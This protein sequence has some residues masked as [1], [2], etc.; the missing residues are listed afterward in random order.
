M[1]TTLTQLLAWLAEFE[2]TTTPLEVTST[3]HFDLDEEVCSGH[4]VL[5]GVCVAIDPDGRPTLLILQRLLAPSASRT[6]AAKSTSERPPHWSP[7]HSY[8]VWS[9]QEALF[10]PLQDSPL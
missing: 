4:A 2:T 6:Y 7:K 3:W 8:I 10:P 9:L 1:K 5:G